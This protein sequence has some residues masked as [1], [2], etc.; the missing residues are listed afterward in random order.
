M[1]GDSQRLETEISAIL[2][3]A[4]D[5]S[6]QLRSSL[7]RY[8]SVLAAG[9]VE[10]SLREILSSYVQPRASVQV[11]RY[12]EARLSRH[13]NLHAERILQLLGLFDPGFRRELEASVEDRLWDSLNS[14]YANR[15]LVAHGASSGI[16]VVRV[17][18]YY[19]DARRVLAQIRKLLSRPDPGAI[20]VA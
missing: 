11:S 2:A 4:S 7:A 3:E 14:I 18:L 1:F 12:V 8:I 20:G 13:G 10:S 19:E 17:R 15:N 16:T 5:C 9:Y 6:D